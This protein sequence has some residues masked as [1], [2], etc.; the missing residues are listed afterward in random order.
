[1]NTK[2]ALRNITID[3]GIEKPCRILHSTDNHIC[4]ADERDCERKRD[5]SSKRAAMFGSPVLGNCDLFD[6][7][8]RFAKENEL[9]FLSTGD[10]CDFVSYGCLDYAK[11]K[12]S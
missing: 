2:L 9:L 3:I 11:K 7:S 8:I 4:V 5:L 10:I 6:E 12:L 1:M